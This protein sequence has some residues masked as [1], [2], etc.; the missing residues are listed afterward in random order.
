MRNTM[1]VILIAI[2]AVGAYSGAAFGHK[3]HHGF[4]SD[5][6]AQQDVCVDQSPGTATEASVFLW[7]PCNAAQLARG[8]VTHQIYVVPQ[9]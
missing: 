1:L 8:F 3:K 6:F 9:D 2:I 7:G 4:K 5:D